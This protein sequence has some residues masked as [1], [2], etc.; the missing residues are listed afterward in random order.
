MYVYNQALVLVRRKQKTQH[1][2]SRVIQ[3]FEKKL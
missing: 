1:G 2:F 3:K